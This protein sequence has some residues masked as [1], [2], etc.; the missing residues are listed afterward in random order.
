MHVHVSVHS[1]KKIS[2]HSFDT[3]QQPKLHTNGTFSVSLPVPAHHL[4]AHES[5]AMTDDRVTRRKQPQVLTQSVRVVS[6]NTRGHVNN[7][8]NP[9]HQDLEGPRRLISK[10]CKSNVP[11]RGFIGGSTSPSA[12][13]RHVP[14]QGQQWTSE[15]DKESS[16][17]GP[18]NTKK[19]TRIIDNTTRKIT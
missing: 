11:A 15:R 6:T 13:T 2:Q 12:I 4:H 5:G 14:V 9:S 7:R 1:A 17:Y 18:A 3:K 16:F 10:R 19:K 8:A